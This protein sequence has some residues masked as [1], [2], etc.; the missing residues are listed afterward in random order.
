MLYVHQGHHQ[1][2]RNDRDCLLTAIKTRKIPTNLN[3]KE[4]E[5]M[6]PTKQSFIRDLLTG[7]PFKLNNTTGTLRISEK[8]TAKCELIYLSSIGHW[9]ALT[10]TLTN[11]ESGL[12]DKHIFKFSECIKPAAAQTHPN[13]KNITRLEVI[14]HTGWDWYI[15][16][17]CENSLSEFKQSIVHY[18]SDYGYQPTPEDEKLFTVLSIDSDTGQNMADFILAKNRQ[19]ALAKAARL[20]DREFV[21]FICA[22]D[23]F[24][25]E[26]D[27]IDYAGESLVSGETIIEQEEVFPLTK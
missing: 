13:A 23:G 12:I 14:S 5:Y 21:D 10:V 3:N 22:I 15:L 24:Q 4:N 19:N 27:T 1:V 17:P 6:E 26:G 7:T 25:N 18:L 8:V 2:K 16:E 11:I 20:P 9:D